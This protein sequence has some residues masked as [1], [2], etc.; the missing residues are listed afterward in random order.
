MKLSVE[1][2]RKAFDDVLKTF[3]ELTPKLKRKVLRPAVR[4]TAYKLRDQAR[5]N[6]PKQDGY[7]AKSII[8]RVTPAKYRGKGNVAYTIGMDEMMRRPDKTGTAHYPA[9][10]GYFQ[11]L[12]TKK[13]AGKHFM[14]ATL[15]RNAGW[16][17]NN[18]QNEVLHFIQGYGR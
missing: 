18:V 13:I 1:L 3:E 17:L 5:A 10:Y 4:K 9:L 14:W 12:G 2:D 7:M 11:E 8:A 15:E 16:V 6:A